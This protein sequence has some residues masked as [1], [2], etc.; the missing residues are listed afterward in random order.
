MN[1]EE[2]YRST[3]GLVSL[4]AYKRTEEASKLPL[5]IAAAYT[6]GVDS[7][8]ARPLVLIVIAI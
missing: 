1:T 2:A 5:H 6:P 7:V 4:H 8:C 3:L